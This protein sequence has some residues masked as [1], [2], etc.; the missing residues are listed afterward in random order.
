MF[1]MNG[2]S[3]NWSFSNYQRRI[4][5]FENYLAAPNRIID[6]NQG[7]QV[8]AYLNEIGQID[9][10]PDSGERAYRTNA[11][12]KRAM[13]TM[14][15]TVNSTPVRLHTNACYAANRNYYEAMNGKYATLLQSICHEGPLDNQVYVRTFFIGGD[16]SE[17]VQT[18]ESL[19]RDSKN[20]QAMIKAMIDGEALNNTL[21]F[22]SGNIKNNLQCAGDYTFSQLGFIS[23]AVMD[24]GAPANNLRVAP[25]QYDIAAMASWT[26]PSYNEWDLGR[27][28][29]CVNAMPLAASAASTV[30]GVG[31]TTV[32][33][34]TN[35]L[36][37]ISAA[38]LDLIR[39]ATSA[40]SSP[41]TLKKYV[42]SVPDIKALFPGNPNASAFVKNIHDTLM[43]GQNMYQMADGLTTL[44]AKNT[45]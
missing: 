27:V 44:Y 8:V 13:D 39:S 18:P 16:G 12:Y 3:K 42:L 43:T 33:P 4:Q 35:V 37:E 29:S 19:N 9:Q 10:S 25:K 14:V 2:S 38:R 21:S 23:Q 26:P 15:E 11:T 40:F 20:Q 34:D 22:I 41:L 5:S 31:K 7:R 17:I 30:K 1:A 32:Q 6:I 36:S 24:T 45:Y 28:T